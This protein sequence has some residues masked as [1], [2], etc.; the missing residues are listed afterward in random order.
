[1]KVSGFQNWSFHECQW[2]RCS[3]RRGWI[4]HNQLTTW[5]HLPC[6]FGITV[7][8][9][10]T[11]DSSTTKGQRAWSQGTQQSTKKLFLPPEVEGWVWGS[12]PNA[13]DEANSQA[14]SWKP[15]AE[16]NN[17]PTKNEH[18]GN[19]E[20]AKGHSSLPEKLLLGAKRVKEVEDPRDTTIHQRKYIWPTGANGVAW[21]SKQN[22]EFLK[23]YNNLPKTFYHWEPKG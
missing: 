11:N 14:Q 12:M 3:I 2:W 6:L 22:A 20:Q 13:Q 5:Y 7:L 9:T 19:A 18:G 16:G 1:M 8:K 17:N 15:E 21:S 23:G 10:R 4:H